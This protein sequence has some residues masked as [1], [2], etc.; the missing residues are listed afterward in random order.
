MEVNV[1]RLR[2]IKKWNLGATA[3]TIEPSGRA[4]FTLING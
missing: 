1:D 2:R 3:E 4:F